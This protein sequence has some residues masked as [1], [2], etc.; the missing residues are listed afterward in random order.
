MSVE[1]LHI[2]FKGI[3]ESMLV[4]DPIALD[5]WGS[6]RKCVCVCVCVCLC[7]CV[8]VNPCALLVAAAALFLPSTPPEEEGHER[9]Y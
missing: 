2:F 7:V 8:C 5:E 9:A 1:T 3:F 6:Y 4:E